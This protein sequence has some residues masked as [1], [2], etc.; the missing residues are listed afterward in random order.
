[1]LSVALIA[2][3][4][5][6]FDLYVVNIAAPTLRTDLH[7]GDA[8]LELVVSGY[9]FTYAAGLVTGGRLGD[10]FGYRT[11]FVAGMAAF[12]VASLLCAL[13]T[14]PG[15]LVAARLLQGLTAAAMVP[16][17]LALITVTFPAAHRARATGWYGAVSGLGA[18]CGQI[19]GGLI[20]KA[21][22]FGLG[23]RG[24]FVVNVPVGVIAVALGLTVLPRTPAAQKAKFD[25]I[26]ALTVSLALALVLV[27]LSLGRESGWPLWTWLCLIA[28][29]PVMFAAIAWQR[30]LLRRGGAPII[31][32]A[33]FRNRPYSLMLSA[34]STYQLYFGSFLFALTLVVQ[35]WLGTSPDR[36]ALVFLLQGVLFTVA[37]MV[38]GKLIARYR[39]GVPVVG[40]VLVIAGLLLI[41]GELA[42]GGP[43]L[44]AWWLVPPLA[45]IGLGNGLLLPPLIG[46]AL[47]RVQPEQAGAASGTLNTAQQFANSLG[48]TVIGTVF[49]ALAGPALHSAGHA[50]EIL[51]V[52]YALLTAAVIALV[53]LADRAGR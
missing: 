40:G 16:Q 21:D 5:A 2:A 26:G 29:V 52:V 43:G 24:I 31:N 49:F 48:V 20:L 33:L 37:S 34:A 53:K 30:S 14:T 4:M 35:S 45:V 17:V 7:A 6:V 50:M 15:Q 41:T 22:L 25:P 8:S 28:S 38:G 19:L 12:S 11:M 39:T 3:F 13:A 46:G 9:A 32:T 1:M 44:S 10:R 51:N 23:W 42:A 27:P 47:S 18:L 36:A